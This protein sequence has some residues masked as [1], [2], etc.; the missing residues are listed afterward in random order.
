MDFFGKLVL[1]AGIIVVICLTILIMIL[2][3]H[4]I[5]VIVF[6]RELSDILGFYGKGKPWWW[7]RL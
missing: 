5:C 4:M 2:T 7:R 6:D 3:I 1:I